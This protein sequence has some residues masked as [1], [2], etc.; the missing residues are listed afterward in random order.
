[1]SV[2][3][4]ASSRLVVNIGLLAVPS[5]VFLVGWL[6]D[7]YLPRSILSGRQW[8]ISGMGYTIIFGAGSSLLCAPFVI[9]AILWNFRRLTPRDQLVAAGFAVLSLLPPLVMATYLF[10]LQWLQ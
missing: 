6:A 9:G 3:A 7:T 1:M 4:R 10:G 5:A 2:D 8:L